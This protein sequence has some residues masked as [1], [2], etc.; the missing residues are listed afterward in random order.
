MI[1]LRNYELK[2]INNIFS[3]VFFFN[4]SLTAF[5]HHKKF[6]YEFYANKIEFWIVLICDIVRGEFIAG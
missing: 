2:V 6:L 1:L 3:L 5:K 4:N